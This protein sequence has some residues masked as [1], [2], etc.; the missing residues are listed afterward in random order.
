MRLLLDTHALLWHLQ[1]ATER[2][3]T[4]AKRALADPGV[5][6]IVSH[7]SL[8]EIAIKSTLGKLALGAPLAE[9]VEVVERSGVAWLPI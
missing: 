5:E 4:A 6:L 7:A 8:W 9:L 1:G 3:S 2:L